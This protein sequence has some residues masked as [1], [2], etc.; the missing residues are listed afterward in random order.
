MT[1]NIK[2][3]EL[4]ESQCVGGQSGAHCYIISVS[5]GN[6]SIALIQWA[7]EQGLENCYV[8]YCDT[9]W[10][11]PNWHKRV[12]AGSMLAEKYGF[13]CLTA[14]SEMTFSELVR[15]KRGFPGQ[16]YQFCSGVLKGV[17]F[18]EK[19]NSLD[20]ENKAVVVIGKRRAESNNRKDTP[21]FVY[22]SE[23]H[24]C[25]TVWHPLYK[26]TDTERNNLIQKTGMEVLPNRS[27]ECCPCVNANRKDLLETPESQ[28][29]KVRQL[30][31]ETGKTM[32]RPYRHMGATGIDEVLKWATSDTGKYHKGQMLLWNHLGEYCHSGLCGI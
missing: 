1:D 25:R 31:L 29:E 18:L 4:P 32:F 16:K 13:E 30:E 15:A 22:N 27:M 20:P 9:G 21:E 11:H 8:V 19:A 7:H 23:Y 10:A 17:P 2:A 14:K 12:S 28:L 6:D 3:N 24:E 5:Y 26:H